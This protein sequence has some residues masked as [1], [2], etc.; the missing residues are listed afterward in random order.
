MGTIATEKPGEHINYDMTEDSKTN[1][2]PPMDG[3]ELCFSPIDFRPEFDAAEE[4]LINNDMQVELILG[5]KV[6]PQGRG[7]RTLSDEWSEDG[8]ITESATMKGSNEVIW[9]N[10][11]AEITLINGRKNNEK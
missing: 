8:W 1:E 2:D 3:L 10:L 5:I 9:K 11:D 6:F 7:F 4:V